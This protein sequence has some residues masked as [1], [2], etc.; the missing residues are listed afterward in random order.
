MLSY[1]TIHYYNLE[2][3][4]K[5]DNFLYV[6]SNQINSLRSSDEQKKT[7]NEVVSKFN[8]K[9]KD[10]NSIYI[11]FDRLSLAET[12]TVFRLVDLKLQMII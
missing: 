12:L 2:S 1:E 4:D 10:C 9:L 8:S 5:F 7:L 6:L 11:F 3:Y